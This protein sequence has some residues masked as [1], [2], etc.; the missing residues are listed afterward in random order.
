MNV[1]DIRDT[2][3]LENRENREKYNEMLDEVF[4]EV[5]IA[6]LKYQTSRILNLVDE[7]AYRCGFSDWLDGIPEPYKCGECGELFEDESEA[8]ECC[9]D[10]SEQSAGAMI[11]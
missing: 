11:E 7:T 2:A 10:V 4:G 3:D 1:T 5:E 6:G 8:E 9:Q